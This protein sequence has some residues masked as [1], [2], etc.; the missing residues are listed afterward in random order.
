MT[1]VPIRREKFGHRH[2]G[3]AGT[4]MM[5]AETGMSGAPEG[6]RQGRIIL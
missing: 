6:K 3:K 2:R 5:E 4:W 1:G